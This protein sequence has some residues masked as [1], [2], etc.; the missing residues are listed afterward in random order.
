MTATSEI[1][2]LRVEK[3][4]LEAFLTMLKLFD[5]VQIE[6]QNRKGLKLV[7]KVV[8]DEV[9]EYEDNLSDS[10][11]KKFEEEIEFVNDPKNLI[12]HEEVKIMVE[13]WLNRKK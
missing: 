1:L 2:I 3:T 11:I 8:E 12:S 13:Q 10:E 9:D 5:F 7:P 6:R 4:K